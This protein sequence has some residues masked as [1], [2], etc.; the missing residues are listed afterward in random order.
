MFMVLLVLGIGLVAAFSFLPRGRPGS[1]TSRDP[2]GTFYAD[3]GASGGAD[4]S[5]PSD[6]GCSDGG[7]GDGGGGGG[8]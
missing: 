2:G 8:D 3:G 5:S 7:G 6:G 4:C 1:V